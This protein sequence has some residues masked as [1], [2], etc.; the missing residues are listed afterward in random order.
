MAPKPTHLTPIEARAL[1][2]SKPQPLLSSQQSLFAPSINSK[3]DPLE[4]VYNIRYSKFRLAP[5]ST[6]QFTATAPSDPPVVLPKT[7]RT[8]PNSPKPNVYL[9]KFKGKGKWMR[10]R[11]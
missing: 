9:L 4:L 8:G 7:L 11:S 5:R 3:D 10:E 6:L 1:S 2:A